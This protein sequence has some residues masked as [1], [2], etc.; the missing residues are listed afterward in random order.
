MLRL[1][2]RLSGVHSGSSVFCDTGDAMRADFRADDLDNVYDVSS[3]SLNILR[4]L[5]LMR[6]GLVCTPSCFCVLLLRVPS[7]ILRSAAADSPGE[8]R[9]KPNKNLLQ[10]H[11][12]QD[13]CSNTASAFSAKFS[14]CSRGEFK[15][16]AAGLRLGLHNRYLFFAS[17][18]SRKMQLQD[19]S[20]NKKRLLRLCCLKS[21]GYRGVARLRLLI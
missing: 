13:L 6:G 11:S 10:N 17:R 16:P 2:V 21:T 3:K 15:M 12:E 7:F 5:F 4:F 18:P 20:F 19:D 9:R 1:P 14:K 8:R